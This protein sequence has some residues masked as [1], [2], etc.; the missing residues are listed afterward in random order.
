MQAQLPADSV[1]FKKRVTGVSADETSIYVNVSG[2]SPQGPFSNVIST[3]PLP[4]LRTLDLSNCK[5]SNLQTNALRE[6]QYGPAIKIGIQFSS[7]W[8]T[9]AKDNTNNKINIVGGQSF[10]DRVVHT[11]VYPS[12][13]LE[14]T[15]KAVL[16]ASYCWTEDASRLGALITACDKTKDDP[17]TV[18]VLRDLAAIH[19]ISYQTLRD[20]FVAI[21]PFDW[22]TDPNSMGQFDLWL[23]LWSI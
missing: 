14:S 16:I 21:H 17:L 10:T 9:T 12:Y 1:K 5:L 2:D 18:L 6:L 11:V 22:T 7:A 15:G 23:L 20:K 13:G 8:W 4:V 19:N 3:L